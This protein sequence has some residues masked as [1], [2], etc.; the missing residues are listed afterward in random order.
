[1]DA[2]L[3]HRRS[4]VE[5]VISVLKRKYGDAVSS[6]VWWRQFRE[7]VAVCLV[8]TRERAVK[9]GVT[10]LDW[11]WARLLYFLQWRISTEPAAHKRQ[12]LA[13]LFD[14]L[15]CA[16][17]EEAQRAV[18]QAIDE[19]IATISTTGRHDSI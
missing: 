1:M 8:Y 9:L 19:T 7:L 10:L 6:R 5:T 12:R 13:E 16:G 4:L 18:R 14:Q 11:L 17:S 2:H 3:Y 15:C